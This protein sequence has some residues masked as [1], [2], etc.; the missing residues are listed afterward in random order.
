MIVV[1]THVLVWA[2]GDDSRL[3]PVARRTIAT[4]ATSGGVYVSA[5]TSWEIAMLVA[6]GRM[7]LDRDIG[8]WID[9]AL[10]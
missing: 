6:K 2:M 5:I 4:A 9:A 7:A 3:G 10:A 8:A 1:D